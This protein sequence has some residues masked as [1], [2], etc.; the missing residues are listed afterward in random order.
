MLSEQRRMRPCIADLVRPTY[1]N[2]TDHPSTRERPPLRGVV[3]EPVFF[4]NHAF[5]EQEV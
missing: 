5:V 1:P 2:L 3:G 4:L